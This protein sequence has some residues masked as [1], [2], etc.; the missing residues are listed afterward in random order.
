[1]NILIPMAGAG[2]RFADQGY[3]V[4]KPSIPTTSL[5][6]LKKIPMV[7][8]AV[9]DLPNTSND[10]LYFI[11][12]DFHKKDGTEKEIQNF[13]PHAQFIT[14]DHLTEGQAST[15]LFARSIINAPEELLIAGCDNGM[16]F[17]Q[18]SFEQL[19]KESDCLIFTHRGHDLILTK[20]E[21]YGWVK[22]DEENNVQGVSVK[23]SISDTPIMDHAV[24][25]TFWF[26]HGSD[27]VE[28]TEAMIKAN[29]RIN[30]EFY[31][32]QAINY[33]LSAGLKIKV[34]EIEKYLC[35]GT[36]ED[37]ENYEKTVSY[38]KEFL[39]YE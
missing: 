12:R 22:V 18:A 2:S 9:L 5:K 38:W 34:F 11:D 25:A 19:R 36:P 6:L 35:W 17:D 33:A 37:Y 13:F 31:V 20:P 27:F 4:H 23:K 14:L 15:C 3:N 1:M 30:G 21:A 24:V 32:D 28:A 16:I 26:K 8:A 7:V 29:D 10:N 39:E